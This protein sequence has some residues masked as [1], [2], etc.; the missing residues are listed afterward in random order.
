MEKPEY[1]AGA[2]HE[3]DVGD[4]GVKR[5]EEGFVVTT[6]A[7]GET[8]AYPP[9]AFAEVMPDVDVAALPVEAPIAKP[10]DEPVVEPVEPVEP[11]DPVEPVI[12]PAPIEEPAAVIEPAAEAQ[13]EA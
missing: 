1:V 5:V 11:I 3:I 13:P 12:E 4:G 2:Y 10:E 8:Q 9:E 7:D 6:D